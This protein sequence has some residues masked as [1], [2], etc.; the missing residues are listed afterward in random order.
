MK[1]ASRFTRIALVACL[2]VALPLVA[3]GTAQAAP[4]TSTANTVASATTERQVVALVFTSANPAATYASLNAT[5]QALFQDSQQHLTSTTVVSL[6]SG[7]GST[8]SKPAGPLAVTP[9]GNGCWY[10]Y[11]YRTWSDLGYTEGDTWMQL[12]WCG[13]GGRIT[14][15]SLS[16]YGGKSDDIFF[17]YEGVAGTG[18]FNAGWEYRQYVEFK[19]YYGIGPLHGTANPCMQIRGGATG[20]Q[21][22]RTTC[23]L[24]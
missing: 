20:L 4:A 24:S 17:T 14:S 1:L 2:S 16:N 9:N 5:Q 15:H 12:N 23:N 22:T 18:G 6:G 3:A 11:W 10:W 7:L 13:S 21:S 8:T 19:F